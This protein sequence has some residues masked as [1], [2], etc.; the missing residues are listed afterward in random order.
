MNIRLLPVSLAATLILLIGCGRNDQ[1]PI[2]Q[3]SATEANRGKNEAHQPLKGAIGL[4][5]LTLTNPFFKEIADSMTAEARK[6]GY[7]VGVVSGV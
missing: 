2:P 3:S 7:S 6:H 5:V 1:N 4:S